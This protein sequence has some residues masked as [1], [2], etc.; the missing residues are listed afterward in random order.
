MILRLLRLIFRLARREPAPARRWGTWPEFEDAD[1]RA[2][3][4]PQNADVL[5]VIDGDTV[6]VR[7]SGR[8]TRIRLASIDCPEDGQHWGDKAKFG[9]MKMIAQTTVWVEPHG[10][11]VHGRL[12][13]TL[14]VHDP[15]RNRVVNV[16]ERMI[17][18]GHAWV[19]RDFLAHLPIAKQDELV[20]M[21]N[22]ART[23]RIGLWSR[24]NPVPPWEW[25]R[26]F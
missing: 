11:D 18:L 6:I 1:P 23:R 20:R 8:K 24:P 2:V 26:S 9:L 3:P 22:W 13:A 17:I 5:W 16:N 25:R 7:L 21:E 12:L 19:F 4:E 15:W 10:H 14:H